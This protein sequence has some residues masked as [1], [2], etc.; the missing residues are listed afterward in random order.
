[1]LSIYHNVTGEEVYC[2]PIN[3]LEGYIQKGKFADNEHPISWVVIYR[4][5]VNDPRR[6]LM[7]IGDLLVHVPFIERLRWKEY[8]IGL[9]PELKGLDKIL[10]CD[11]RITEQR[12]YFLQYWKDKNQIN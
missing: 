12:N 3:G 4:Y 11:L 2:W 5:D 6:I 1:M 9:E 10:F 7:N 8:F